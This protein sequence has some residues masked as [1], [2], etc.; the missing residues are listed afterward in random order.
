MP[1]SARSHRGNRGWCTAGLC[2]AFLLVLAPPA[3]AAR[4][5]SLAYHWPVKPFDREHPIR[6]L[7]GDP[8]TLATD[9]P[10]GRT[11]SG[12]G[13]V[14]SFHNGVDIVADPGTPVY[15]VVSGRVVLAGRD[16][17]VVRTP[18]GR[19]FQ[20]W[21]LH[22]SVRRGRRVVVDRTVLGVV[23]SPQ[24]HVHLGEI[25]SGIAQ[26]PLAPGHLGPYHD[27]TAPEATGLYI[28]NGA[29][30]V[31]MATSL[32]RAHERLAVAAVDEPDLFFPGAYSN[33]PVSPALVEWRLL[34]AGAW[35]PWHTSADFRKTEPPAWHFWQ[36]YA[37]GTYQ[38]SPVFDHQLYPGTPGQYLFRI[39]LGAGRLSPGSYTLEVRV[40]DIRG[41]SSTSSWPLRIAGRAVPR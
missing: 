10:F 2:L 4:T 27:H 37:P 41:N 23:Q 17:I 8:R 26:N 30:P 16:E 11:G 38:N 36:V 12:D 7:F 18:D 39:D 6:A 35:T 22:R 31:P 33:L 15:P 25:D 5:H 14:Y 24:D 20:Y 34:H 9:Q 29:G 40:A 32:L 13:G 19:R 28:E 21:H 1:P 3:G